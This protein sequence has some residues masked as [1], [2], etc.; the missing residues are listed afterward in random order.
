V[1]FGNAAQLPAGGG[2]SGSACPARGSNANTSV[3]TVV[4]IHRSTRDG[5]FAETLQRIYV[6]HIY[7]S[8]LEDCIVRKRESG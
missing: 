3:K 7:R 4:W 1:E 5:E 6:E 8:L 2:E